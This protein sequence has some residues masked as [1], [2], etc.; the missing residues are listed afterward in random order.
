VPKKRIVVY[1]DQ[2][3]VEFIEAVKNMLGFEDYSGTVRF[4]IKLLRL[5]LPHANYVARLVMQWMEEGSEN[6]L[7][8]TYRET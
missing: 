8:R 4:L 3:D 7:T 6:E 1:L 5:I 2:S